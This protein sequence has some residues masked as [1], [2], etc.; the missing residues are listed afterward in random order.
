MKL[1]KVNGTDW[2]N[3]TRR[4]QNLIIENLA[5]VQ[6]FF[7]FERR[8]F[9]GN[10]GHLNESENMTSIKMLSGTLKRVLLERPLPPPFLLPWVANLTI[11]SRTTEAGTMPPPISHSIQSASQDQHRTRNEDTERDANTQHTPQNMPKTDV[12][13]KIKLSDSVRQLLPALR[14]QGPHYI[15]AHIYDRP[16][17]LTQGDTIRLPFHMKDVEPGD[18]IR[19]NRAS[20]IGSRDYTLKASAP[21]PKLRS[22][23]TSTVVLS[24]PKVEIFASSSKSTSISSSA[25]AAETSE[26]ASVAPHFIP[27]IAK[28]KVSYLDERIFVCRAVVMGVESEPMQFKEKTKRRQR[29]VKTIKS[30]HRHTILRVKE[31]RVRSVEEIESGI[32]E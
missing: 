23:T 21:P 25:T 26:R 12:T 32:L 10:P 6:P 24:D 27:H 29:K 5:G 22:S 11:A 18:V 16:Y 4:C 3:S 9:E 2:L 8:S 14:A 13:A 19:L 31:V 15:T 17:L 7:S 20:N 30:K 1:L 28:G